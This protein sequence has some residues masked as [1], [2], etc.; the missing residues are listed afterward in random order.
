MKHRVREDKNETA[1]CP[2]CKGDINPPQEVKTETG[3]FT[4]GKCKC[5]AVYVLDPT[6]H[7]VGEA[8]A[9]ALSYACAEGSAEFG[10][11]GEGG[12]YLEA[13]FNYDL[14]THKSWEVKDIRRDYSGK[15]IFIK[16]E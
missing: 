1:R 4:G 13:V 6:G 3:G 11:P 14:R 9:D 7:N 12:N 15:I 16:M 10:S 5:G 8:F 2:F